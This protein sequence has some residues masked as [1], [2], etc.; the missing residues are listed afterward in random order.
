MPYNL[1]LTRLAMRY[2]T[3]VN[4]RL[5]TIRAALLLVSGVA[6]LSAAC[7]G[8]GSVPAVVPRF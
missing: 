7:A 8:P 2:I 5:A 3:P 6:L 4:L 1:L